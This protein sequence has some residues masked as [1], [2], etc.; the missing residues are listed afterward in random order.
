MAVLGG[1]GTSRVGD[2]AGGVL[3]VGLRL[4]RGVGSVAAADGAVAAAAVAAAAVTATA[5]AAA[6]AWPAVH[7]SPCRLAP[8]FR[9]HLFTSMIT[10]TSRRPTI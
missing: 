8:Q 5:A 9:P 2:N 6:T 7:K 10:V 1:V 4:G 3:G